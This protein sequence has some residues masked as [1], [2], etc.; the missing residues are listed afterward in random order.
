MLEAAR[1]VAVRDG[2]RLR[3]FVSGRADAVG[4]TVP[5]VVLEGGVGASGLTWAGVFHRLAPYARVV[6]YDRA[7]YGASEPAMAGRP[8]TLEALADDLIDVIDA[9]AGADASSRRIVLVGHSWGGPIVRVAAA[10]LRGR[11]G[12]VGGLVL[13][14][15]SDER[16]D[17]YFT[18]QARRGGAVQRRAMVPIARI[19]LLRALAW[20]LASGL[21]ERQRRDAAR[22]SGS[23]A[24]ARASV[25]ELEVFGSELAALRT[26]APGLGDVPVRILSGVRGLAFDG[27]ARGAIRAAHRATAAAVADGAVIDAA[28]SAHNVPM[29]EPQLVADT[30][31]ALVRGLPLP[32]GMSGAG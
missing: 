24:A 19:G 7:G 6:A 9:C 16:C 5:V 22:A 15:P 23:V 30:A 13:V 17:L 32:A 20:M 31:L 28:R 18:D 26:A 3:A 14:D 25:R 11:G 12:S 21:P 29:T 27:G 10:R 8:R 1:S 4:E 2:R